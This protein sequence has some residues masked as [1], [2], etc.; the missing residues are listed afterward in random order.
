MQQQWTQQSSQP[1]G[2]PQVGGSWKRWRRVAREGQLYQ[3]IQF[4]TG[5]MPARG[6]RLSRRLV[7]DVISRAKPW[8]VL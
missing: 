3:A 2:R 1:W 7:L 4:C 6:T 8:P 5:I